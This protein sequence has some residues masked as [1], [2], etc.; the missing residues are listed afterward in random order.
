MNENQRPRRSILS[1][2]L[3]YILLAAVI[4]GFVILITN[5][6]ANR[7]TTISANQIDTVL[8]ET[9]VKQVDV[10][11]KEVVVEVKFAGTKNETQGNVAYTVSIPVQDYYDSFIGVDGVEH[12]SYESIFLTASLMRLHVSVTTSLNSPN[13]AINSF[14][15]AIRLSFKVF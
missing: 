7:T 1:L 8:S 11:D 2:I 15:K 12:P 13:G 4:A 9:T 5:L 10:Y 6:N 3:P 14:S